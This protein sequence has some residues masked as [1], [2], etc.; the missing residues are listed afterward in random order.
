MGPVQHWLPFVTTETP[1]K[2]KKVLFKA[3][4]LGSNLLQPKVDY[5]DLTFKY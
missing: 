3:R 4:A 1:F 5:V 2:S